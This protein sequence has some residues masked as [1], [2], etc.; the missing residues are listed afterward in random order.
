M[1]VNS[2]YADISKTLVAQSK[3][4]DEITEENFWEKYYPCEFHNLKI[5][6]VL[7]S[8]A[9][10]RFLSGK[11]I[12]KTY[13]LSFYAGIGTAFT[14]VDPETKTFENVTDYDSW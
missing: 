6:G 1:E 9:L 11:N 14:I 7:D 5:S 3:N 10:D 4:W 2:F 13:I 12:E 8:E